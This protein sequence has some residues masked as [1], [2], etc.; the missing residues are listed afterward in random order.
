MTCPRCFKARAKLSEAVKAA[1]KGDVAAAST[2]VASAA[3]SA[4]ESD[5]AREARRLGTRM[6]RKT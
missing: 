6:K 4:F 2:S 5:A 1:M 3:R